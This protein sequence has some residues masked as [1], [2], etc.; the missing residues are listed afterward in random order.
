MYYTIPCMNEWK[1]NNYLT[2][3]RKYVYGNSDY[4]KAYMFEYQFDNTRQNR[5]VD[6]FF[7]FKITGL[8]FSIR[9]Y[10]SSTLRICSL[11]E[12]LYFND[13]RI[14][15]GIVYLINEKAAG[16]L[17]IWI[18]FQAICTLLQKIFLKLWTRTRVTCFYVRYGEDVR[19]KN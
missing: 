16:L 6:F 9:R 1:I 19:K 5:L 12:Y 18:N 8:H 15:F 13:I 11:F 2:C 3:T 7:P 4:L 17:Y 14:W 10:S